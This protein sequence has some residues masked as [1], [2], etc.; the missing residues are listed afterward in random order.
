MTSSL[1]FLALVVICHISRTIQNYGHIR[2]RFTVGIAC[3]YIEASKQK[4]ITN[5]PTTRR[6]DGKTAKKNRVPT[7]FV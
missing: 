3:F 7:R 4:H 1:L 2:I 5:R 6:V